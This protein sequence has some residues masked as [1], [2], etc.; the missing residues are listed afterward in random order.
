MS[1]AGGWV[2]VGQQVIRYTGIAGNSLTGIPPVGTGAII[3][4][5][6]YNAT[7]LAAPALLG[8][9]GLAVPLVKGAPVNIFVQRDDL[10]AQAVLAAIDGSD[11][12]VEHLIVDERRGEA[13]LSALCDADLALF[14][15]PLVTVTYATRDVK[16]KSGKTIAINLT[17]P[18]IAITLTIQT[19]D[20]SEI[21]IAHGLAPRYSVSAS[22]VDFSL[23]DLLRRMASTLGGV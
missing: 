14:S 13:S 5:I 23:D 18:A 9:T 6:N 8:V 1:A 11:G 2:I 15:L 17:S 19:V 7:A 22:N 10:D 4:P 20:I 16:T 12:I 3:A 21:G